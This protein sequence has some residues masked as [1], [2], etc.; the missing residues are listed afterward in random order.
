MRK[1]FP[2]ISEIANFFHAVDAADLIRHQEDLS[3]LRPGLRLFGLVETMRRA[4][5]THVGRAAA[6]TAAYRQRIAH[7]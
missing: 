5:A 3:A 4:R 7:C 2:S 1:I 6:L